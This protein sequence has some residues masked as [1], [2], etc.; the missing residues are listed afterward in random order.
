MI[1]RILIKSMSDILGVERKFNL[2]Q[3]VTFYT[4]AILAF[5]AILIIS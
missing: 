2:F 4:I 1:K 5:V 3:T